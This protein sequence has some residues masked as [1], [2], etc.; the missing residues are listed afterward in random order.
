M[1]DIVNLD[2]DI[3][4]AEAE[5]T[6]AQQAQQDGLA[7]YTNAVTIAAGKA[8]SK[9]KV[10]DQILNT[11]SQRYRRRQAKENRGKYR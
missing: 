3:S 9:Y 4:N 7:E 6:S 10:G 8:E 2:R 11:N 1:G 5:V